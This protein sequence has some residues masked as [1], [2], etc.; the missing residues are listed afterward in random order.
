MIAFVPGLI[1]AVVALSLLVYAFRSHE[2][3]WSLGFMGWRRMYVGL[4]TVLIGGALWLASPWIVTEGQSAVWFPI[5]AGICVAVGLWLVVAG[6]ME[7]LRDLAEERRRLE[8][9]RA[10]FDLYDTLR[11]VVSGPYAFLEILEFA[12]K[13]MVRA[14]GVST[15]GLWLYNAS[16][17]EWVLTGAANMSQNFRRQI[18]SVRGTGTGF[19]RLA[20][21]H[22]AHV[23]S[24]PEEIRLFFPEW[25]AEGIRSILGL[26]LVTG[27]AGSSERRLLGVIILADT[28]E[29]R[30]DDDRARR[31]HAAADYV[32][33]VIAEGRLQRQLDSSVQQLETA[34]AAHERELEAQREQGRLAE[35]RFAEERHAWEAELTRRTEEMQATL[36]EV[37]RR[38]DA[39]VAQLEAKQRRREEELQQERQ[40]LTSAHESMLSQ[41]RAESGAAVA[42]ARRESELSLARLEEVRRSTEEEKRRLAAE[43][44][45]QLAQERERIDRL[46]SQL[47]DAEGQQQQLRTML[48]EERRARAADVTEWERK[49]EA[50]L[51]QQ[52][53]EKQALIEQHRATVGTLEGRLTELQRG[54]DEL[55]KTTERQTAEW[56]TQMEDE[57]RLAGDEQR[58]LKQ[59]IQTLRLSLA[60]Q[61]AH[62]AAERDNAVDEGRR[63][64]ARYTQ[65][66]EAQREAHTQERENWE[67]THEASQQYLLDLKL[68]LE[69]TRFEQGMALAR[70][71]NETAF[72][73]EQYEAELAATRAQLEAMD[74]VPDADEKAFEDA[75]ETIDDTQPADQPEVEP[76]DARPAPPS[77]LHEALLLWVSHQDNDE[78][79]LELMAQDNPTVDADWLSDSL[80]EVQATCR[81]GSDWR[82]VS[83]A[84][85]TQSAEGGTLLLIGRLSGIGDSPESLVR[86]GW[87]VESGMPATRWLYRGDEPVGI[88]IRFADAP[89]EEPD[90]TAYEEQGQIAF[91][92]LIVDD[93][94]EMREVLG[95]MLSGLGHHVSSALTAQEAYARFV[96]EPFDLVLISG[97]LPQ[98]EGYALAQWV[99]S[100]RSETPA[101]LVIDLAVNDSFA[102]L[103]EFHA[104][105]ILTKPFDMPQLQECIARVMAAA[106]T[107]HTTEI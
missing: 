47:H 4:A 3:H 49:V 97:D 20:R 85:R 70:A 48:D 94:E 23:F 12:L 45:A 46:Q 75:V 99:K 61:Q 10:G 41:I 95:G 60:D 89:L 35:S 101:V 9:L 59:E 105:A 86:G 88:E 76:E 82:S 102:A 15:G 11:E 87:V 29:G 39:D 98:Q 16:G 28:S 74:Q 55:Q 43:G 21:L 53:R 68:E 91:E 83:F 44:H 40:A 92:I 106:A 90:A 34:K 1:V 71:Q 96:S 17:R 38:S 52:E 67:A 26:P 37:Q 33:A 72:V 36:S 100:H 78:W 58:T 31:L 18:E 25:E 69:N 7:R 63:L 42:E 107:E 62:L 6:S 51:T 54:M 57:R 77:T 24:R 32:A 14:S 22:K 2:R 64:E 27:G 56:R 104:D 30:F 93:Q 5:L 103:E 13:E 8:E 66:L 84:V 81:N 50:L 73:R 65:L 19:D 80:T 79:H